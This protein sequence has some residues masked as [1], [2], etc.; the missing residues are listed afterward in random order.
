MSKRIRRDSAQLN[1]RM[2]TAE[3]DLIRAAI[4]YGS[5]NAVAVQL[6]LD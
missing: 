6:L 2:E 5:V 4:P 3:R 1:L